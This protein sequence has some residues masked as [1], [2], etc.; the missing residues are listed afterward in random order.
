VTIRRFV[1]ERLLAGLNVEE[2]L[3]AAQKRFPLNAV[4]RNYVA[5]LAREIEDR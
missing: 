2:T 3:D 1:I 4:G 5:R